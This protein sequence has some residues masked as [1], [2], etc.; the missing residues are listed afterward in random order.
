M[1][2][3]NENRGFYI[4]LSLC[5]T[6]IGVAGYVNLSDEKEI[7]TVVSQ[8]AIIEKSEVVTIQPQQEILKDT[9]PV[10]SDTQDDDAL[11]VKKQEKVQ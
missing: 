1:N 4:V 11:D 5:I 3:L 7:A 8:N 2:K 6:A 9:T 10:N